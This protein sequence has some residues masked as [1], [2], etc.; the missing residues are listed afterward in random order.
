M[1]FQRKGRSYPGRE[2]GRREGP[3]HKI[4]ET[5]KLGMRGLLGEFPGEMMGL[6]PEETFLSPADL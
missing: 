5:G 6:G 1:S 2:K 3:C 4:Q